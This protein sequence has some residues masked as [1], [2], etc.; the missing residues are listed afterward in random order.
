[1]LTVYD[2]PSRIF[3]ALAAGANG[4]LLKR[5]E[6]AELLSAI[7]E[8]HEGGSPM[9]GSVAR[10]VVQSFHRMG[11]S[12]DESENL[13]PREAEILQFLAEGYLYKEIAEKC[14]IGIETVRTYI[15]RIYDKLHVRSRTEAVVKHLKGT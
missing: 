5:T 15:K 11:T 10:K 12:N 7:R 8:L 9:S 1:V 2:E 3:Q 6:P 14:S 4:Y 13:S